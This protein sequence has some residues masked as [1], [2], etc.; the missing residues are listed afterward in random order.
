M[1]LILIRH[2]TTDWNIAR[3]FQ[4]QSNVPL[5]EK[6]RQQAAALAKRLSAETIDA[7][8][9]SDLN[10]ARNTA[11][12]IADGRNFPVV[13]DAR[14]REISFGEW[15][16]LTYDEIRQRAPLELTSWES[17]FQKI[18]PPGGE[19]LDQL[20]ARISA[21]LEEIKTKHASQTVLIV[22]HGGP[23]QVL[24]CQALELPPSRYWQFHLSTAAISRL[25]FYPAGAIIDVLNDSSHLENLE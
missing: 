7:I 14:L 23:L 22:A 12:A 1:K 10:R 11:Q 9:S 17:D 4:G 8:Y 20:A 2:G 6:G 3:R 5:N 24:L 19:T 16:G 15:E 25:D 18:P 13:T 21:M